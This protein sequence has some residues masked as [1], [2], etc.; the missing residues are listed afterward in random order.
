MLEDLLV[1]LRSADAAA[2]SGIYCSI[3]PTEEGLTRLRRAL[4]SRPVVGPA[5]LP[6]MEQTLGPQVITVEGVPAESRFG[7]GAR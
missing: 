3:D 6:Q 5:L 2:A 4:R 7:G 1:A